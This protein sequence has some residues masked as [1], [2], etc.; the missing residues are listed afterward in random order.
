MNM[1]SSLVFKSVS[2]KIIHKIAARQASIDTS[3][4][5]FRKK[6][7]YAKSLVFLTGSGI[8]EESGLPNFLGSGPVWRNFTSLAL[9]YPPSFIEC[10]SLFWEFY[11]Y[12]REL[13]AKARPNEVSAVLIRFRHHT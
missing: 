13:A 8:S 6:L 11:N 1:I 7:K 10:P 9:T 12:R 5:D 2:T 4:E 3:M